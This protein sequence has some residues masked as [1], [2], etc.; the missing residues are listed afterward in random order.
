MI[1]QHHEIVIFFL[2]APINASLPQLRLDSLHEA[3][4]TTP[5][6]VQSF[7]APKYGLQHRDHAA[8]V[9]QPTCTE[10]LA[11]WNI[12]RRPVESETSETTIPESEKA[13][14]I[15]AD[16]CALSAPARTFARKA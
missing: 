1:K 6:L 3:G 13:F 16:R 9:G 15:V 8:G 12:G 2:R 4:D 11:R 14:C 7:G 10:P 5:R